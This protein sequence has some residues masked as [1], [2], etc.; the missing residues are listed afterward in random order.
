MCSC[1]SSD[2]TTHDHKRMKNAQQ[3]LVLLLLWFRVSVTVTL[4]RH[5]FRSIF[6]Q[7]VPFV[8]WSCG[9]LVE[10]SAGLGEYCGTHSGDIYEHETNLRLSS[11]GKTAPNTYKETV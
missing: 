6:V 3:Q 7:S 10:S 9:E 11:S 5:P 2:Q 1:A 4:S 8:R